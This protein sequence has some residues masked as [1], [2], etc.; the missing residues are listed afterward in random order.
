MKLAAPIIRPTNRD[1][2]PQLFGRSLS[3]DTV[4]ALLD[5]GARGDLAAQSDL[6]NLMEDTWPRLR[7]NLQKIKNAIRKLPLNVQPFTPKNGKPSA[8]AQEKA[9]FVESALHLQRGYV[10]TTRAP[11]GS[12]VYELMD[13]V[14]RGLSVV[15][16]DWTTDT[17]GFVVPVGFRRV[18]SRYLGINTDGTLALRLDPAALSALTPFAKHPGK[19]LTGI[20]QSKS[21]A[22]G[23]A[24]QLRALAP[25]W[26][27]HMLGWEWLVQKAELFGTPLRWANYPTTATQAEIDAITA[28]LRNMGTASWGAFPQGTNL[29]IMQGT[30]PGVAGPND[31]SERLMGIADRACDIMLLGQNLSVEHNG[32]GS[33]AASEVHREVELDLY[34]TYA[35]FIV[36]IL[37][38]QLIP[39]LI[40]LNWGSAEEIPYVEVEIP[41]PGREHD[42]AARDKTLFAEMGLPVSLQY[43]Y[44]RHKVPSPS[45]SEALFVP[46]D[47]ARQ[48]GDGHAAGVAPELRGGASDRGCPSCGREDSQRHKVPSSSPSEA[49]FIPSHSSPTS[50]QSHSAKACACGCGVPIDATSE[51]SAEL[52]ARQAAAQAAFPQQVA[53]ANAA[54]EYL[55]WD[56]TLD[57]RTTPLCQGRHGRRWGD[58]W[59]SPPPA[60]YNCRSTLIRVPKAS[61]QSPET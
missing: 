37:N 11:L 61:Y 28:A 45:P 29:Q 20:F 7:A 47:V 33:R 24:A 52:A 25:L 58:G 36:A 32:Q 8:S 41:R 39:Q 21:G 10:D 35:E 51:S 48:R 56:A 38:D 43:L 26:L 30:T 16:I 2:E 4:G 34:E 46:Y 42:M 44:E 60:H 6:F 3:P 19:F 12:A 31:P 40:A 55:V 27:G 5:A 23:E 14:A 22:L 54:D 13:A 15:E 53:E 9:A 18:P 59:F 1:Y 57:N 50:S 17:T 49:L